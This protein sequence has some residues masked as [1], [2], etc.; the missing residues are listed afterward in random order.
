[1]ATDVGSKNT[2]D[3]RKMSNK[4]LKDHHNEADEGFYLSVG[5]PSVLLDPKTSVSQNAVSS[6]APKRDT[7]TFEN[8]VN[9]LS[10]STEISLKT[11]KRWTFTYLNNINPSIEFLHFIFKNA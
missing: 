5:S 10:S 9:M 1:M 7:Y 11:K 6:I 3:S 8:S 2:A 4:K